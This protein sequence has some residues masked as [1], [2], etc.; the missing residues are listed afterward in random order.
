MEVLWVAAGRTWCGGGSGCSA[1]CAAVVL[2]GCGSVWVLR[3]RAWECGSEEVR[4]LVGWGCGPRVLL[5]PGANGGMEY[6]GEVLECGVW[7]P[8]A[9][10]WRVG[11]GW[12]F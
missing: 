3:G 4:R 7:D 12:R 1:W 5:G 8:V 11:W 6:T 9:L 2:R 10:K